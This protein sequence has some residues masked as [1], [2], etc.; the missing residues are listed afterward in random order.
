M[1]VKKTRGLSYHMPGALLPA[2]AKHI[3]AHMLTKLSALLPTRTHVL[4][5]LHNTT[6]PSLPPLPPK[7]TYDAGSAKRIPIEV[8]PRPDASRFRSSRFCGWPVIL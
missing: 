4:P 1:D 6:P 8:A 3:C 2:R 5:T 7:I